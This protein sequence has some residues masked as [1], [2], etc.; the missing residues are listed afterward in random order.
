MQR[1]EPVAFSEAAG[2]VFWGIFERQSPPVRGVHALSDES[3]ERRT[4]AVGA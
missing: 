3:G 4:N 2:F 1:Q